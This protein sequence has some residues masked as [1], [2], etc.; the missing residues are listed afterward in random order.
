MIFAQVIVPSAADAREKAPRPLSL[1]SRARV[2]WGRL[3][4]RHPAILPQRRGA[5]TSPSNVEEKRTD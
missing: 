5:F 4:A 3:K 2:P 1:N